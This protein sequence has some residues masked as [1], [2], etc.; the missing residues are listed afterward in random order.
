MKN[1][2]HNAQLKTSYMAVSVCSSARQGLTSFLSYM[3]VLW[4]VVPTL[5]TVQCI[6]PSHNWNTNI[7]PVLLN[8]N[9]NISP[10]ETFSLVH[11]QFIKRKENNFLFLNPD[12]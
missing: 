11:R 12:I 2:E 4:E 8:E 9:A 5:C 1:N 7:S 3:V 10:P 6:Y